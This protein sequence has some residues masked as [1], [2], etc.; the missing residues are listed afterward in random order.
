MPSTAHRGI[1]RISLAVLFNAQG[2]VL[3]LRRP[4]D[5]P[6]GGLWSFPG[7]KVE[8]GETPLDAA[9]RE[10]FEETGI[11]AC[12]WRLVGECSFSYPQA[13]IHFHLFACRSPDSGMI[14]CPEPHVWAD[15]GLLDDYRMP[16]ANI[17][18]L[19]PMVRE[20]AAQA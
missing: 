12:D 1:Q 11:A 10:L 4:L 18:L 6:Q 8:R 9:R 15:A 2:E 16:R 19:N 17:E 20:Y 14:S 5:V 7:G 3:L 13:D